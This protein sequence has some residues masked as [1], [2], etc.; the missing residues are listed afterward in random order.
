MAK[1]TISCVA[2]TPYRRN[3]LYGFATVRLPELKLCIHDVA[4]HQ[5]AS[6]ARWAALPAKPVIDRNGIAK[7]AA[8]EEQAA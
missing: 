6:G 3:T 2:F 4:Q 1:L 7:R 8:F 5:Y